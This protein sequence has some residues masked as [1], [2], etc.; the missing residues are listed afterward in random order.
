MKHVPHICQRQKALEGRLD[1]FSLQFIPPERPQNLTLY[2]TRWK[3]GR[4]VNV[5]IKVSVPNACD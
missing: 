4:K 3:T 2:C 1:A 5:N